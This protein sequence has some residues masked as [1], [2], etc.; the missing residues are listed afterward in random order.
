VSAI[1]FITDQGLL[2]TG[3]TLGYVTVWHLLTSGKFSATI[4]KAI[5]CHT[6]EITKIE[7]VGP[8][9]NFCATVGVDMAVRLWASGSMECVGTFGVGANWVVADKRTWAIKSPVADEEEEVITSKSQKLTSALSPLK[10]FRR[11]AE[12]DKVISPSKSILSP[13]DEQ[14]D[15]LKAAAASVAQGTPQ[16]RPPSLL[17]RKSVLTFAE[18]PK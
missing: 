11:P 8:R 18:V 15:S 10:S 4:G 9:G 3:D 17:P 14:G 12:G 13:P 16:K 7:I 2:L 1:N 6:G 5:H